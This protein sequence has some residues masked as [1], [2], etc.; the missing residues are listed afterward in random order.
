[1]IITKNIIHVIVGCIIGLLLCQLFHST[2]NTLTPILPHKTTVKEI[3][4]TLATF[5]QKEEV[6][7]KSSSIINQNI[8]SNY[9]QLAK[10]QKQSIQLQTQVVDIIK[11]NPKDTISML[12]IC[13][14]LQN[15]VT[16]LI[17]SNAEKDSVYDEIINNLIIQSCKKDSLIT[18]QKEQTF[19]LRNEVQQCLE[20]NALLNNQILFSQKQNKKAK[21]SRI[22]KLSAGLLATIFIAKQI[23]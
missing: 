10:V 13:D 22:L 6:L 11:S 2:N 19:F 23:H 5:S 14:S 21:N 7:N 20:T 15:K 18:I 8:K 16:S 1:M 4:N 12:L 3:D 17:Q 9:K